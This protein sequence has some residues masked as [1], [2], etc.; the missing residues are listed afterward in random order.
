MGGGTL[1]ANGNTLNIGDPN[2]GDSVII[3]GE[4]TA[5]LYDQQLT[6]FLT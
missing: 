6:W 5:S 3:H 1:S 4:V 2:I